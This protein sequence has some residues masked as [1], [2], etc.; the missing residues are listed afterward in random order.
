M[1]PRATIRPKERTGKSIPGIVNRMGC[2]ARS[3]GARADCR[4]AL[5]AAGSAKRRLIA[6][7]PPVRGFRPRAFR[8]E[9]CL[10]GEP[11]YAVPPPDCARTRGFLPTRLP[12][13]DVRVVWPRR[14]R[15]ELHGR[16]AP[17]PRRAPAGQ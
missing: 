13:A 2:I 14:S 7:L 11:G 1:N 12:S 15:A 6:E 4:K 5:L 8:G 9:R 16:T 3:A 17:A 10:A